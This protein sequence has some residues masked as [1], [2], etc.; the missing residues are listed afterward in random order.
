MLQATWIEWWY[1]AQ[2]PALKIQMKDVLRSLQIPSTA[3]AGSFWDAPQF[4]HH[5][6][7]NTLAWYCIP[8]LTCAPKARTGWNVFLDS[9]PL[10][11]RSYLREPLS[12]SICTSHA[13]AAGPPLIIHDD[14]LAVNPVFMYHCSCKR[15]WFLVFFHFR[16]LVQGW[17]GW[18]WETRWR[19]YISP[20]QIS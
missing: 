11:G 16:D 9:N 12:N 6:S 10:Q 17:N 14:G 13:L 8:R 7:V 5:G 20:L 15:P 18:D 2:L 3:H 1:F 19:K 4:Q